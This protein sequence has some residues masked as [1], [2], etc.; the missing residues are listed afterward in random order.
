MILGY[1]NS[2]IMTLIPSLRREGTSLSA[3]ESMACGTPVVS[4]NVGG[5][6]DLPTLQ[7]EPIAEDLADK[8]VYLINN[9]DEFKTTQM[10]AVTINFNLENWEKAWLS[11]ILKDKK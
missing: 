2:A 7:T 9:Y 1:Y 10:K 5:L 3:L 8:M 6:V 11:V 4:T